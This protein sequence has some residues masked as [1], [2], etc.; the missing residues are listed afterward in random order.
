MIY[1]SWPKKGINYGQLA[2]KVYF[3]RSIIAKAKTHGAFGRAH[4][5]N[6]NFLWNC[7]WRP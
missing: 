4:L 3:C 7:N 1:G 2:S 6:I 5:I